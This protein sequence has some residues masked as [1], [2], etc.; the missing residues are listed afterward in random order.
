MSVAAPS[1]NT[2]APL[3]TTLALQ[4]AAWLAHPAPDLAER[5][6]DLLALQRF[7]REHKQALC[8]AISADYGNRSHHETLLAEIFPAIDGI[9][10]VLRHL[11]KWMRPQRRAVDWRNFPGAR[12]RVIP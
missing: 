5:R 11:K 3:E 8:E 9:D 6:R 1:L 4:R 10:H 12:N 2:H 7:I